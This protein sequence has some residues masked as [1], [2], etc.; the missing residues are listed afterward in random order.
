MRGDLLCSRCART[1]CIVGAVAPHQTNT[2]GGRPKSQTSQHRR[3]HTIVVNSVR[4]A[5]APAPTS[6]RRAIPCQQD[7]HLT[8][9]GAAH[10]CVLMLAWRQ[11]SGAQRLL[12]PRRQRAASVS[13]CCPPHCLPPR[14]RCQSGSLYCR[15]ATSCPQCTLCCSIR[16]PARD[17]QVP[18][19]WKRH[20]KFARGIKC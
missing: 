3:L 20:L 19:R 11:V 2:D 7:K 10:S 8:K 9:V 17:V 4:R 15:W 13:D 16:T 12:T 6:L 5:V 1:D 14:Q 18:H